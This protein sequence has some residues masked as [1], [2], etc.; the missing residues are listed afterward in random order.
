MKSLLALSILAVILAAT[1]CGDQRQPAAASAD[2][3]DDRTFLSTKVL[4]GSEERELVDGSRIRLAFTED[5]LSAN[6][7]CNTMHGDTRVDGDRLQID[8]MGGTEMGCEQELMKQDEWLQDFLTGGPTWRLA[9]DALVL[10]TGDTEIHLV[11]RKVAD[12]DRPL[13]GTAWVVSEL[14]DGSSGDGTVS[15]MPE[16]VRA[17]L[18]FGDDGRATGNAGCN[19]FTARFTRQGPQL[20]F[21]ELTATRKA[22]AGDADK[23][24][25]AVFEVLESKVD[26]EI[27]ADKLTLSAPSGKGIGLREK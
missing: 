11:D 25:R 17:H 18:K 27:E 3:L 4:E 24:E 19:T 23:V 5:G 16:G 1:G 10:S 2:S 14:I 15:S 13:E 9:G 21:S 26:F 20:A 6:A 7:G 22:C 12:P 8:G